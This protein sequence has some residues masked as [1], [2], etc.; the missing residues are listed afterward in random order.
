MQLMVEG[1]KW[2]MYI[3][4]GT[5][6]IVFDFLM[7]CLLAGTCRASA[8]FFS[9]RYCGLNK[10]MNYNTTYT[11]LGY[12][13]RGSPPKIGGGDV[14]VFTMEILE[15]QG[16][17]VPAMTC[18]VT[19]S[20]DGSSVSETTDCNEKE[21]KYIQKVGPWEAS[22]YDTEISRLEKMVSNG[23]MKPELMAWIERRVHILKQFHSPGSEE[24]EL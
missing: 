3:P 8:I 11:E 19:L 4:S 21:D 2:E 17:K 18:T 15:I 13:D 6:I 7:M 24:E 22:K 23:K 1:D 20:E 9:Y 16:G 5:L 14:L 10:N 12:G